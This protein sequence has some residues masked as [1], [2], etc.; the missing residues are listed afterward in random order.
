MNVIL[1]RIFLSHEH[2]KV[3]HFSDQGNNMNHMK[4]GFTSNL[5][6]NKNQGQH[7]LIDDTIWQ[8]FC[9]LKI[10][11]YSVFQEVPFLFVIC[12]S[13]I[14]EYRAK[15]EI[16][17]TDEKRNIIRNRMSRMSSTLRSTTELRERERE[18]ERKRGI[19]KPWMVLCSTCTY[20]QS[21]LFDG[22]KRKVQI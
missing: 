18:R 12:I 7:N 9:C 19:E 8:Q 13:W 14:H 10:S 21:F 20:Y 5:Q 6:V 1:G 2:V 11:S 17:E 16:I 15:S 22:K 4:C 3:I